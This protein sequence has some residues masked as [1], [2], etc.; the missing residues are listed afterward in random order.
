M[1]TAA[2]ASTGLPAHASVPAEMSDDP[3]MQ[4]IVANMVTQPEG[5]VT[6]AVRVHGSNT[7]ID[8]KV[9]AEAEAAALA[10]LAPVEELAA[11]PAKRKAKKPARRADDQLAAID[12]QGAKASW[13]KPAK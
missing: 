10:G 8:L 11:R 13:D 4:K 1:L 3:L 12:G 5:G 7:G 6:A 2:L 9:G